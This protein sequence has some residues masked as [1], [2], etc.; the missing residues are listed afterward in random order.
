MLSSVVCTR[1][2]RAWGICV[3]K[4]RVHKPVRVQNLWWLRARLD[5]HVQAVQHVLVLP[6][7][8][9]ALVPRARDARARAVRDAALDVRG[10]HG[11][12]AGAVHGLRIRM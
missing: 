11:G 10:G 1:A 12:H 4:P 9:A 8:L 6:L 7:A 2:I 3:S 5:H